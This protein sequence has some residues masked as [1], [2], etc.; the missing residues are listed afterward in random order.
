MKGTEPDRRPMSVRVLT[1]TMPRTDTAELLNEAARRCQSIAVRAHCGDLLAS[2]KLAVAAN[3]GQPDQL[4]TRGVSTWHSSPATSSRAPKAQ[5]PRTGSATRT[6]R[7]VVPLVLAKL[8]HTQPH[9]P[10]LLA[11]DDALDKVDVEV[12][13]V[14]L[15][16]ATPC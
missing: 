5:T 14:E 4:A 11:I 2:D 8:I 10:G 13:R 1:D 7:V 15:R 6:E 3:A 16:C 9:Q 12:H